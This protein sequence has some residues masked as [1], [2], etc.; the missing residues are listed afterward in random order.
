MAPT[1][2]MRTS[3]E[4]VALKSAGIG[5]ITGRNYLLHWLAVAI[6]DEETKPD[7]VPIVSG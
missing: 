6:E 2:I 3:V 1:P 7:L 4:C 5:P